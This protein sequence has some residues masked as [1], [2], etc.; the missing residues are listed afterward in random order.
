MGGVHFGGF[1]DYLRVPGWMRQGKKD[2][3]P[4][5]V[6]DNYLSQTSGDSH[7]LSIDRFETNACNASSAHTVPTDSREAN[8]YA[9]KASDCRKTFAER[10]GALR[11]NVTKAT[12]LVI[13]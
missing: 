5:P 13:S 10:W 7:R 8:E 4:R 3:L 11:G 2:E 1:S 12:H 9:I 6:Q